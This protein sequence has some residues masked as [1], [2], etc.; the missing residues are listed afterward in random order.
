MVSPEELKKQGCRPV[1]LIIMDGFGVAP[2][3][4]GNAITLA[5]TPNYDSYIRDYPHTTLSAAGIDVGLP[6]GQM[7]NSEVGHLNIG[8]GRIVY[9]DLTR[10]NQAI[11]DGSFFDNPIL[12]AAV[13]AAKEAD[14][15]LHLMGLLSDGG[16]HSLDEH[17]FALLRM[18]KEAGVEKVDVHCFLDGRDTPP[19]SAL[20]YIRALEEEM[21]RV[22]VGR[23]ATVCGRYYAMDRDHRWDR[24]KEAYDALVYGHG[25]M[26]ETASAAVEAAYAQDLSDEFVKPTVIT[27]AGPN[28][29]GAAGS[30]EL[31]AGD[32]VIFFNFRSDRARE[33]T[34][35]LTVADFDGFD[36]GPNPPHLNFV[37]LTEYDDDCGLPV[38]FG[39]QK[40]E[41]ILAQVVAEDGLRQLHIAET[42]KYTHVT[43]F[44]NGGVE[45]PFAGEDRVLVPSPKVA[46]YDLQPQMSADK[47][48]E[49]T[50]EAV[51]SG[52]YDLIIV[53]FANPDMVGHTG[54]LSATIE[55][56]EVVDTAVRQIVDAVLGC[57]GAAVISADHGNAETMAEA[58]G[59]PRTAH[60]TS[61]V[62]L[63]VVGVDGVG[64]KKGAR[65]A[66]IAPTVLALMGLPVPSEMTGENLLDFG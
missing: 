45:E 56:L 21:R 34:E 14:G 30:G 60:S 40:L 13:A 57:G 11:K 43:F 18:A 23:I 5:R 37:C 61:R 50:T 7:G 46:T 29:G 44:F 3:G 15:T 51:C 17:I 55:A 48:V 41:N 19:Q 25:A 49:K 64:L 20:K 27:G 28:V 33:M 31:H 9:Q 47:V 38:A 53:N 12:K 32:T 26:A 16:V 66:D 54:H 62:P 4:D 2:E 24:V 6:E 22:G 63:I 59:D 10:I 36:R 8:S 52:D 65:L 39:P 35:A 58:D 1:C 42:E